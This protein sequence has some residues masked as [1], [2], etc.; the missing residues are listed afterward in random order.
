MSDAPKKPGGKRWAVIGGIVGALAGFGLANSVTYAPD[1]SNA[2]IASIYALLVT[3]TAALGAACG[4]LAAL[5]TSA[6][7]SRAN[8]LR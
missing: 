3:L 5:I 2:S 8:P 6:V 1:A 4:S 7:N